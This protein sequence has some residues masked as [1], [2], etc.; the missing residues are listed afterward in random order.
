MTSTINPTWPLAVIV[1][2]ALLF[3]LAYL[4]DTSGLENV[5]PA[6]A[7]SIHALEKHPEVGRI[8]QD[9]QRGN[10]TEVWRNIR[11]RRVVRIVVPSGGD[12]FRH[13]MIDTLTGLNVT[14]FDQ[15][16]GYVDRK[17]RVFNWEFMGY[18]GN[19]GP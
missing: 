19:C 1:I 5:P 7:P 8:W 18:E 6:G 4:M 3:G 15:S 9:Y 12:G 10:C 2:V 17:F 14:M 16:M 11:T 13:L